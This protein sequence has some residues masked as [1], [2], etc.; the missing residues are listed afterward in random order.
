MN[1]DSRYDPPLF[2]LDPRIQVQCPVCKEWWNNGEDSKSLCPNCESDGFSQC[3]CGTVY[4]DELICNDCGE[5][6]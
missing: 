6:L 3:A 4:T 1:E 5:E 2:K